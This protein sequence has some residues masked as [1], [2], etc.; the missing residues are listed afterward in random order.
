METTETRR[1][2]WKG[3]KK[4]LGPKQQQVLE[5][6]KANPL[7]LTPWEIAAKLSFN[8]VFILS[9]RPRLT[10]LTQ[11]GKIRTVGK[12]WHEE[13]KSREAVYEIEFGQQELFRP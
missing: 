6:L 11:M 3:V 5:I 12:R 2:S 10:E 4:T 7:G 1:E 8:P 13:T 9:V